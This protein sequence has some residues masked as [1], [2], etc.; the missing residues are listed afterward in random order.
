[1]STA[2]GINCL[3]QNR[4][5]AQ[6]ICDCFA[7]AAPIGS[8]WMKTQRAYA[9]SLKSQRSSRRQRDRRGRTRP[10]AARPCQPDHQTL[11]LRDDLWTAA[12]FAG[13]QPL[14]G[15]LGE[16]RQCPQCGST[17]TRPVSFL[18][19]LALV[20]EQ[21]GGVSLASSV[22][23]RSAA[24]LLDWAARN[25]PELPSSAKGAQKPPG[26]GQENGHSR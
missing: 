23:A 26:S 1:M 15:R 24:L 25:L 2:C 18:G 6:S 3:N 16:C 19:A 20:L 21:L 11:K 8:D 13:I 4:G 22:A 17:L 14:P 5:I 12:P 10:D 9:R 7:P